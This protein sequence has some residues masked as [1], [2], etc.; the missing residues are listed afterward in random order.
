MWFFKKKKICESAT[1]SSYPK[2]SKIRKRIESLYVKLG[3]LYVAKFCDKVDKG[4]L[5]DGT[6]FF[7]F[8]FDTVYGEKEIVVFYNKL[9]YG[10]KSMTVHID[11]KYVS[12]YKFNYLFYIDVFGSSV[13]IYPKFIPGWT[14]E[15]VNL[16]VLEVENIVTELHKEYKEAVEH[17]K[18]V[19]DFLK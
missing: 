17:R 9:Y 7:K 14:G 6:P 5:T 18:S 10:E 11:K 12:N 16:A 8:N 2:A 13:S 19:E 1:L 3:T 4:V 15:S